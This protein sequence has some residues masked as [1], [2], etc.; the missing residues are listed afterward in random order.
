VRSGPTEAVT[1]LTEVGSSIGCNTCNTLAESDDPYR[2]DA[3]LALA[4]VRLGDRYPSHRLRPVRPCSSCSR[5]AGHSVRSRS[6]V[7][8]MLRPSTPAAP[9]L[10]RTRFQAC[11][12]FSLAKPRKQS[13]PCPPVHNAAEASSLTG[14]D[15]ASPCCLPD[16]SASADI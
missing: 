13:G 5:I 4:S 14:A 12:M 8:S 2:R 9:L 1:V 3:Q 16:R 11:C 6:E 10:D 7:S 15:R